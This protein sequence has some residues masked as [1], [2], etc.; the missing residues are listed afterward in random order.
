[1]GGRPVW[2]FDQDP[3]HISALTLMDEWIG[4]LRPDGIRLALHLLDV[5]EKFGQIGPVHAAE[6]RRRIE[7]WARFNAVGTEAE[8]SG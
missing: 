1:M 5:M 4:W 8:P 3:Q 6:W 2:K 7:G